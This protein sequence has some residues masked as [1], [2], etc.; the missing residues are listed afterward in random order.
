MQNHLNQFEDIDAELQHFNQL[1]DTNSI[2]ADKYLSTSEFKEQSQ[3]SCRNK[4]VS[5]LHWNARS[6]L[7]KLDELT[8]ELDAM[9]GN[10]DLLC[11]CET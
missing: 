5:V 6:L 4:I 8:A 9:S 1:Y 7:P 11:F 3:M 2:I 10:F